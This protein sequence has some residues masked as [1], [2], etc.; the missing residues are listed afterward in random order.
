MRNAM[1]ITGI[2]TRMNWHVFER[3][4]TQVGLAGILGITSVAGAADDA[5]IPDISPTVYV[6]GWMGLVTI[7]IIRFVLRYGKNV[8]RTPNGEA[9]RLKQSFEEYR[10]KTD[11]SIE[12][13][14][15]SLEEAKED[16]RLI[17]VDCKDK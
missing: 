4:S 3:L 16:L 8:P 9:S 15:K 11:K 13:L 5:F 17:D 1:R 12:E 14:R 6:V 2:R 10:V 7:L